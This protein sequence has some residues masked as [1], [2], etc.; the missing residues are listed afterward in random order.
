MNKELYFK[1]N[2]ERYTEK[3]FYFILTLAVLSDILRIPGTTYTFF[4]LSI[5][6]AVLII[7]LYPKW[8]RRLIIGGMVFVFINSIFNVIFYRVYRTD[9]V[10]DFSAYI[11]YTILYFSIFLIVV[12]I[13]IIKEKEG[14]RFEKKFGDWLCF[15]G[16]LLGII[17]FL[18]DIFPFFFGN[19]PIDNPNNY[20]CYIAAILPIYLLRLQER[21]NIVFLLMIVFFFLLLY[22][23]DCKASLFGCLFQIVLLF[24]VNTKSTKGSFIIR[25]LTVPMLALFIGVGVILLNPTING[26]S[27]QGIIMEPISRILTDNPY[28]TYT[29]SVSFRTNTTLFA[30]KQIWEMK[31]IGFGAGNLGIALKAEF[32]DLNPEYV[33]A[34]NG[35]SLNLHNAWLEF[36]V[37]W[38][39]LGIILLVFPLL[40]AIKLYLGKNV[41]RAIEKL[42]IIFIF[43]FP[44][45][46][47]GPSNV[48][49]MYFLFCIILYIFI[50]IR[51]L[52][53]DRI[54]Y[55]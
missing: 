8:F 44:I 19:L 55:I 3:I 14:N 6:I 1:M 9:L 29:A 4:R 36:M 50:N 46:V 22:I 38:G 40:Y 23:N 41:L 43:S 17:L 31:G 21:K 53:K 18:S 24:C 11:K 37:D 32:P 2:N 35:S 48:Y 26:Y 28:P 13:S 5:P 45:W 27:L 12:L 42:S 49:T 54:N 52:D 7:A 34:L 20:G 15:M 39:F 33:Q 10:F 30:L 47:I 51:N 16:M 25:R